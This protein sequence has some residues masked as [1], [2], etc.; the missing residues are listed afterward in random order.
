MDDMDKNNQTFVSEFLLLGLSGYPKTEILYFVIVLVMYLVIL[1]GNGVLIIASIFD[2]HLHTPMYFF[3]GNLSFLDICYTTSSVP[4]TLVSLISK[5]RNISFSGCTVQMFVGF[6][7]GSTECLLL[8]MMAFDRYVAICNPL[9]YSVIMSKEVYV[10]M[11]SASWFS[12]GINS[13]VQTSLAMRLPFCGNNVI[14]HFTCEVLA[15]L[16]LAC[17]DISLNIVTM[18]I[19]NMAF[20]VLPLLLIFF[21]YV[22]ILYT[23]LR[24]NSA[25]GRRKAFSTCSAH[26]TVVVIFYGTI[27]SM[28]AKPKSQDLTGKDKFQTSDKIISLF[29]G[30]VT[31]MLNPI[32]YSL[33][34]KDVKAAVKYILKQKYI[35]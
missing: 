9:R 23:I 24:M 5:K 25:S 17:A 7:M 32:I 14:N 27:F 4:S 21:S 22:F 13:V 33:R 6:A 15:V 35:P 3:L 29:Y 30:V 28:Y 34:N 18:V 2:S 11:A 31:P 12:G 19:S 10:S 8:G 26:L 1:T 20:L 16:K